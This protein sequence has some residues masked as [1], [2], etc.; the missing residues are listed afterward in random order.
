MTGV[1]DR[2]VAGAM[3]GSFLGQLPPA[4]VDQL[5]GD[6]E[7]TEYPAGITLYRQGSA[8]RT[9]LV[10]HGLIRVYMTSPEGRQV[11]VRYARAS[12]VLNVLGM[13]GLVGGPANVSVQTL[14]DSTL[15]TINSRTL[16]EAARQ[17]AAVAWTVAEELNRRLNA[18]LH[19]TA[20]NAFGSVKQRV[21]AHL[22]DLASTQQ[23][24]HGQLLA[25]VSQQDLADAIGSVREVAARALRELR[26]AGIVA[27]APDGIAIL[28]A[29]RLRAESW[30]AAGDFGY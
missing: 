12:D 1:A 23:R 13:T 5:L 29:D 27:T 21:A 26:A 15:F 11:T 16:T 17:D 14:V 4:V 7:R 2:D 30:S 8:P 10:V 9:A 3:A 20:V 19:Q 6:G 28:D 24:P 18:T 22:L 25:Q